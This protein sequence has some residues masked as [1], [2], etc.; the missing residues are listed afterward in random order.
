M[1]GFVFMLGLGLASN[2]LATSDVLPWATDD[3]NYDGVWNYSESNWNFVSW[4][5]W[6]NLPITHDAY[7]GSTA[8]HLQYLNEDLVTDNS[9]VQAF[10]FAKITSSREKLGHEPQSYEDYRAG[11]DLRRY[12]YLEFYIKGNYGANVSAFSVSLQSPNGHGSTKAKLKDFVSIS[13]HWQKVRIPMSAFIPRVPNP[14]RFQLHNVYSVNFYVDQNDQ[15]QPFEVI[16]DSIKFYKAPKMIPWWRADYNRNGEYNYSTTDMGDGSTI[17]VANQ[18]GDLVTSTTYTG[19]FGE[20]EAE[21]V[22]LSFH[23]NGY[24]FAKANLTSS[25]AMPGYEPTSFSDRDLGKKI[26][27]YD[28]ELRFLAPSVADEVLI[29]LV[30]A[31]GNSSQALAIGDYRS[32]YGR[33]LFSYRIPVELFAKAGFDFNMVKSVTYF[34]DQRTPP[35]DYDLKLMNLEFRPKDLY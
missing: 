25:A 35:G 27:A 22:Q 7:E 3:L 15:N 28:Y 20:V 21:V 9:Y 12:K 34:V 30:D 29:K 19:P 10:G 17:N 2:G 16:V 8:I 26:P 24:G 13:H 6:G 14:D 1:K 33:Y 11:K 31:D 4:N 5:E 18:W 23:H 32:N